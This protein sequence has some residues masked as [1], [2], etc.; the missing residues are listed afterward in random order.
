MGLAGVDINRL[1]GSLQGMRLFVAAYEERSFTAAAER[2]NA[3]QSGVSQHIRKLEEGF[4]VSLFTR[5][6]G[7]VV[8]TPAGDSYYRSCLEVLKANDAATKSVQFFVGGLQGEVTV[9]LM[10]TMTR[11]VLAPALARFTDLHPNCLIR[12]VEAYS[13]TL[14]RRVQAAE[15]DFAIVPG[16]AGISGVRGRLYLSTPEVLVASSDFANRRSRH[17]VRLR[18]LKPLRIV[19]PSRVNTRRHSIDSYFASNGVKVERVMELDAMFGM[20]DLVKRTE[21]VT[22]LP[23]IMM[24]AEDEPARLVINPLC[25]PPMMLDLMLI[26]PLRCTMSPAAAAFLAILEEEGRRINA[27][28][29]DYPPA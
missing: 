8:P 13:D 17:P 12:V 28:W 11:C 16:T 7:R 25:S 19:V 23:G 9:G 29:N 22:V 14:T 20:L 1:V 18:D 2:E 26:E 10:P 21:W 15:L 5:D 6:T 3:T 4:R 24:A 27:C